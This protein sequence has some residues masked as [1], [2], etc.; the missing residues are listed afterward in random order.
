M[1]NEATKAQIRNWIEESVRKAQNPD[2]REQ[3]KRQRQERA[4][5]VQKKYGI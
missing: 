5:K 2:P 4:K 1:G 3:L